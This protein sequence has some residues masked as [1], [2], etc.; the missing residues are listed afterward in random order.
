MKLKS[1]SALYGHDFPEPQQKMY[2][3]VKEKIETS[4]KPESK[5]PVL[6][7]PP[8]AMLNVAKATFE[9]IMKP[10]FKISEIVSFLSSDLILIFC[11][12]RWTRKRKKSSL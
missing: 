5:K 11:R 8:M 9:C 3:R 1:Q 6:E 2:E 7:D 10:S 12:V 4:R